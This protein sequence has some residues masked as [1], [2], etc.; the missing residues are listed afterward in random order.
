MRILHQYI[1]TLLVSG[2]GVLL[3]LSIVFVLT[4]LYFGRERYFEAYLIATG[5]SIMYAFI[6][7]IRLY[8]VQKGYLF[9]FILFLV[10]ML[11]LVVVQTVVIRHSVNLYGV[12]WYLLVITTIVGVLSFL[13][14][15]VYRYIIFR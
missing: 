3:S 12:D 5:I 10:Y 8:S 7:F 15:F 1:Q 14:F 11:V 13:S 9:R 4:E 6:M 2:S